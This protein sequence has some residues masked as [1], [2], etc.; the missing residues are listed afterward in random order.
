MEKLPPPTSQ[1]LSLRVSRT[2]SALMEWHPSDPRPPAPASELLTVISKLERDLIPAT[3]EEYQE[4]MTRLAD[5]GAGFGIVAP[6]PARIMKI[7]R[8]TLS[9][10]PAELLSIAITRI[11][12][13]WKYGNRMPLPAEI[14]AMVSR[15]WAE[16]HRCLNRAKI[17]LQKAQD[18]RPPVK[19]PVNHQQLDQL[20][21]EFR[22]T[23]ASKSRL[24][25]S[26]KPAYSPGS[27]EPDQPPGPRS[28]RPG[29]VNSRLPSPRPSKSPD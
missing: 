24:S 17:A 15:E 6:D 26:E 8:D 11:K 3:K 14:R 2:L 19:E 18:H 5:L 12:L 20:M 7:Y 22:K 28:A 10:M 16:A 9:P 27:S 1:A 4:I 25:S 21:A 23:M 13:T 29:G